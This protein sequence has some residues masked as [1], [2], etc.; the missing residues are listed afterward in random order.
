MTTFKHLGVANGWRKDP[1]EYVK[2]KEQKHQCWERNIGRCYTE[3]GCDI[4]K[5]KYEVDSSD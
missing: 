1:A 2:C 3:Y 5:I 4:C